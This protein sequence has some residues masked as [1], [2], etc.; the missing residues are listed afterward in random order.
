MC[1]R[2]FSCVEMYTVMAI[3]DTVHLLLGVITG[4][5]VAP[6]LTVIL[7]Q[8]TIPLT[9][10]FTQIVHP[11]GSCSGLCY[12]TS[13][14]PGAVRS[15]QSGLPSEGG[16]EAEARMSRDLAER[17]SRKACGGLSAEHVWGAIIIFSAVSLGLV[18]AL[19][20]LQD[21]DVFV[22]QDAVP[23]RRAYNT[24]IF[25][26]SC[27]PAAASQLY[28]EHAL[29]QHRQPV[30]A[31]SVNLV[32]SV[33][34][35]SIAMVLSPLVYTLQGVGAGADWITLYPS[36]GT[37]ENFVD[38][39]KCFLGVLD[40]DRAESAYPEPAH[41]QWSLAIVML[42]VMSAVVVGFAVDKIVHAGAIKVM[43]RGVSA[44]VILAIL[45]MY[46][47][48][49]FDPFLNYGS[50]VNSLHLTCTV[51]LIVGSEVYHRVSIHDSTFDTVY[52]DL[53]SLYEDE[54]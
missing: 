34:Q 3:L 30:D 40:P 36:M 25:T 16:D 32:L 27:I 11:N 5:Y 21:P 26:L 50:I 54:L 33:F 13:E 23:L 42:H 20:S 51:L 37:S 38:G 47:Y 43:Y 31:N 6:T 4:A 7:V 19:L 49:Y 52:P 15:N 9:A 8:L 18:P 22:N 39:L 2:P 17:R 45:A 29:L 41:C 53:E 12:R 24:I 1:S 46:V 48:E 44:G 35:F 14:D 28:K 10:F